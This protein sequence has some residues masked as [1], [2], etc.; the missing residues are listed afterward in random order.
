MFEF[1]LV[2]SWE[3]QYD[4]NFKTYRVNYRYDR[5]GFARVTVDRETARDLGIRHAWAY[6]TDGNDYTLLQGYTTRVECGRRLAIARGLM[7]GGTTNTPAPRR[8]RRSRVAGRT[9]DGSR[10]FGV[11]MEITGPSA[12]TII[13][14]LVDAGIG[15]NSRNVSRMQ[16][17]PYDHTNTESNVWTLK[18][19]GSVSGYGLELVSP[20]M[21]GEN[22][23]NMVRTVCRVLNEIGATVD[24]TCGMH[25]HHDFRGLN[26]NDIRTQVLYFLDRQDSIM[27]MVAPSRRTNHYSHGW[28]ADQIENFRNAQLSPYSIGHYGVRGSINLGAFGIHGSVEIRA[29]G[30][31][32]NADKIIAW[33]KFGQALFAAAVA[34]ADIRGTSNTRNSTEDMLS[35]LSPF[36]L[37]SEDAAILLRFVSNGESRQEI[38]ARL[39]NMRARIVELEEL[40]RELV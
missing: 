26:S 15:M 27:R 21:S 14:A 20:K 33:I 2:R 7:Q 13:R 40:E 19:D 23:F 4:G 16:E 18:H 3:P 5:I 11:E 36:G 38:T 22:G 8:V 31:T 28:S 10:I 25:V 29:H 17:L 37:S 39:N 1:Q 12:S 35:D 9:N 30:G 32:V 24:R 34:G 6:S